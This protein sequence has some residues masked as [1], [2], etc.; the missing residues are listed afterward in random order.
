MTGEKN[1]TEEINDKRLAETFVPHF[2]YDKREPF[3]MQG[4]GYT[5]Y[6][7]AAKSPSCRRVIEAPSGGT[8]IEYA[9]YYDY[10]IQHLYDLEHA[11]VYLDGEERIVGVESSFHGKFVNS[12]IEGVTEYE[13]S[14][15]VLYVQ[16]GKH[17]VLA[18]P[19]YFQLVL[20]RERCCL[21]AAGAAGFLV[22][23][24]FA[25]RLSTDDETDRKVEAYLR[26]HYAFRPSWEF[27]GESPDGRKPEELLV[28]YGQ[29]DRMIVERLTERKEKICGGLDPE[30]YFN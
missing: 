17:A 29:L 11:F 27:T 15:P 19:E 1:T 21:E 28:P 22:M 25:G 16:P 20:E 9:L 10:D 6:R 18:S 13:G 4:I 7:E 2:R 30:K 3:A 5:M 8:A 23:D 24:M 26:E 12:R 14:H